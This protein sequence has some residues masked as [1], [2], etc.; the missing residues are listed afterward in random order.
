M[1]EILRVDCTNQ[2]LLLL[3]LKYIFLVVTGLLQ[4]HSDIEIIKT[5]SANQDG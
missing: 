3:P 5:A 4:G 2:N 1:F